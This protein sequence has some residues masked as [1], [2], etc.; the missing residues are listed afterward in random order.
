MGLS[1]L[2][3]SASWH[4]RSGDAL[5][6]RVECFPEEGHQYMAEHRREYAVVQGLAN[7]RVPEDVGEQH[8]TQRKG[9]TPVT[10]SPI[11]LIELV[12]RSMS[13]DMRS[14]EMRENKGDREMPQ[15]RVSYQV[16]DEEGRMVTGRTEEVITASNAAEAR[17]VIA[18]RY[19]GMN[20]TFL[21]T[22]PLY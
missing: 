13:G 2:F 3:V 15:F 5:S 21:S 1:V 22:T 9:H 16:S 11:R 4:R 8:G 14:H 12:Q 6:E 17:R 7:A 18:A 19:F 10:L 20:V